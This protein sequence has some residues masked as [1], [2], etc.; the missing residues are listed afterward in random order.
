MITLTPPAIDK[1]RELIDA[2]ED[3]QAL[4]L[5][6]KAGGC[7]GFQY[8][9]FFDSKFDELEDF[10]KDFDGVKVVIDRQSA[11]MIQGTE[12][13][14]VD[15]LQGAGFKISNPNVSHSCGCGNSFN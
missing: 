1:V 10:V 13:D 5:G 11:E 7:S 2:E 15:G 9:M 8:E 6:V 4:R 12:V 14:F 3:A